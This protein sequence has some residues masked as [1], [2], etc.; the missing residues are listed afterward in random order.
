[1]EHSTLLQNSCRWHMTYYILGK[2]HYILGSWYQP[3]HLDYG[4]TGLS[5]EWLLTSEVSGTRQA[6]SLHGSVIMASDCDCHHR[7]TSKTQGVMAMEFQLPVTDAQ[8]PASQTHSIDSPELSRSSAESLVS[9]VIEMSTLIL[10][11]LRS[12]QSDKSARLWAS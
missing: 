5:G 7:N 1:M 4:Q 2:I 11:P 10:Q 9:S 8:R 3:W 12:R 6:G